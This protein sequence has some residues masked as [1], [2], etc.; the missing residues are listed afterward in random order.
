LITEAKVGVRKNQYSQV[1]YKVGDF[2]MRKSE[3]TPR[4]LKESLTDGIKL[5]QTVSDCS[6][7]DLWEGILKSHELG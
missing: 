1:G 5:P 3:R 4:D 7:I 2:F 6:S